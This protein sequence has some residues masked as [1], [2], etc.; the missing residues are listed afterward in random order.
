[1][2]ELTFFLFWGLQ[3]LL[4]PMLLFPVLHF[5]C[6][7][8]VFQTKTHQKPHVCCLSGAWPTT[9]PGASTTPWSPRAS[10]TTYGPTTTMPWSSGSA[11][12]P[13]WSTM[14]SPDYCPSPLPPPV[15]VPPSVVRWGMHGG[16]WP[17]VN[18]AWSSRTATCRSTLVTRIIIHWIR[19]SFR[20]FSV[21][22]PIGRKN[23]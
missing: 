2:Y 23:K 13:P 18:R 21:R 19:N 11:T 12:T 20:R 22:H 5:L 6:P 7:I 10:A 9:S 15:E 3:A 16:M 14:P 8:F 17:G 1:M 4:F